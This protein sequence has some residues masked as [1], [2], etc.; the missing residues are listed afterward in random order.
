MVQ[1]TRRSTTFL[2]E[3]SFP[4]LLSRIPNAQAIQA[5]EEAPDGFRQGQNLK[6]TCWFRGTNSSTLERQSARPPS[7]GESN[8]QAIKALEEAPDG[9]RRLDWSGQGLQALPAISKAMQNA[10]VVI[11]PPMPDRG[12]GALNQ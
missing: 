8:P 3:I 10:R 6:L 7:I 5:L 1:E 11:S 12:G 4:V 2:V 9:F